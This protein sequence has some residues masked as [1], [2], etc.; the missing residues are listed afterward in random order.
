[1]QSFQ[2]EENWGWCYLDQLFLD[3][4][5]PLWVPRTV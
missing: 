5:D 2:P 4:A 1:M 3:F